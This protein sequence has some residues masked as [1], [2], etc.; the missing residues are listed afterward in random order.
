VV[1]LNEFRVIALT[2]SDQA[3]ARAA[4]GVQALKDACPSTPTTTTKTKKG[5]TTTTTP[6]SAACVLA[7]MQR[8]EARPELAA[9]QSTM[10]WLSR[11][12]WSPTSEDYDHLRALAL[13]L[14]LNSGGA[15]LAL[16]RR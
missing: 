15:F 12:S 13:V 6:E 2:T 5:T 8:V 14:F 11:G 7:K 3:N 9:F 4:L 16:A 1:G 10:T